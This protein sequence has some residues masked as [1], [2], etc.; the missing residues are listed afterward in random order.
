MSDKALVIEDSAEVA[1]LV[2]RMLEK[3]GY[4]TLVSATAREGLSNARTEAPDLILL[5]LSL[6]DGDGVEVCREIRSFSD[7]YLIMVTSRDDEVDKIVGLS[8]GAGDYVTKPF[9]PRELAARIRAMRRRP[10]APQAS[11]D[12]RRFPGLSVN[13]I[14][15]EAAL[16]E[17]ALELTKIEFDL[18]DMLS[19]EPRRTFTRA[20][21]LDRVWGE[22]YGDDHVID[23]HMG[24]LR[25]KLQVDPTQPPYIRTVRGVGYRFDLVPE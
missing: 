18:L 17:Q 5:D 14:A 7:A 22:W 24:N 12:I 3:E 13:P 19:S 16:G 21:V 1:R 11:E 20:Q 25:K 9:S 6:P 2:T 15:R 23:V 4:Q 8:V 10:R